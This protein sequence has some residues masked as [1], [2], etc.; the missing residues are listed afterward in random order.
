MSGIL[1]DNSKQIEWVKK[2]QWEDLKTPE[3]WRKWLNLASKLDPE[4]ADYWK[5]AEGCYHCMHFDIENIWCNRISAPAT[6]NP[7]IKTLGLACGG[8]G[9][10]PIK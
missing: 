6:Y 9:Y 7:I 2:V 4:L 1:N 5:D 10:E 3:Q 8:F